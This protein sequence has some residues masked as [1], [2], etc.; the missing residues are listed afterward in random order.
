MDEPLHGR[1]SHRFGALT[2]EAGETWAC[3]RVGVVCEAAALPGKLRNLNSRSVDWLEIGVLR[4]GGRR[5]DRA[6]A[7][8]VFAAV[9]IK[10]KVEGQ[11]QR[12]RMAGKPEV[13]NGYWGNRQ[14]Q[15]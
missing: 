2:R 6:I 1:I 10:E 3:W 13:K 5:F 15:D 8:I 12:F 4:R 11:E 14:G 7:V 9:R